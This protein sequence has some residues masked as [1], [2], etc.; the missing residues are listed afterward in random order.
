MGLMIFSILFLSFVLLKQNAGSE[1]LFLKT[2]P[3][4]VRSDSQHV[5]IAANGT[6][7]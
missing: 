1:N 4:V 5:H 7:S 3:C 2:I 6:R